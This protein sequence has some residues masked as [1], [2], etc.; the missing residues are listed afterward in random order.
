MQI[1]AAFYGSKRCSI[2]CTGS[3]GYYKAG[4]PAWQNLSYFRLIFTCSMM[5]KEKK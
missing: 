1:T 4:I 3:L 2:F 5:D